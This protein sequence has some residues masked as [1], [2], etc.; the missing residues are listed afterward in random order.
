MDLLAF[1][2][3]FAATMALIGALGSTN[4]QGIKHAFLFFVVSLWIFYLTVR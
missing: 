4:R 2:M 1:L 3:V